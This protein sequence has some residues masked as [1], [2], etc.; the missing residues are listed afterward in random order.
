[1]Y[2]RS[3]KTWV[4]RSNYTMI[5]ETTASWNMLYG[6]QNHKGCGRW[7]EVGRNLAADK[8]EGA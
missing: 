2:A 6:L 8:S 1:M 5:Q 4:T 7:V 3:T